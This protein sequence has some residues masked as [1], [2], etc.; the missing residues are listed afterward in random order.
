MKSLV[1]IIYITK[2]TNKISLLAVN[3]NHLTWTADNCEWERNLD[4]GKRKIQERKSLKTVNFALKD[5]RVFNKC[6]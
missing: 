6:F 1:A 2:T 4:Q 3:C 5:Q